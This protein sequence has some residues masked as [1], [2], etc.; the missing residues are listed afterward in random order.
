M[1][2][3]DAPRDPI[4]T[5]LREALQAHADEVSEEAIKEAVAAYEAKLRRAMGAVAV[6]LFES[7]EMAEMRGTLTIRVDMGRNR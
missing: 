3:L 6:G 1:Q 2:Q 4:A 5:R 7:Y